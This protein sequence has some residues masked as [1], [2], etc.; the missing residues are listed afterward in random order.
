MRRVG[1]LLRRGKPEAVELAREIVGFLRGRGDEALA[2]VGDSAER[3]SLAAIE[4]LRCIEETEVHGALDLLVVLGGDGTLLR[5][6]ALVSD[7]GVPMLGLNLGALGFLDARAA[8]RGGERAVGA[9]S[10]ASWRSRSACACAVE[11]ELGSGE[12]IVAPRLQRR[13][14]QP[15]RAGAAHRARRA[16]RRPSAHALP[17]RRPHRRHADRLDRLHASP[18]AAP[19]STPEV[20]A[21]VVTPIC[22]HTLT[23][24]PIVV[25]RRRGRII[26][27]LAAP[28]EHVLLTIDGQWGTA[29]PTAI[30][31]DI[32][33]QRP[34]A[35]SVPLA[36][37][38]YFDVL[39]REAALGRAIA[40]QL[41]HD[42]SAI[43]DE[44][45]EC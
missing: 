24:R 18:P 38:S 9:R 39:A 43:S 14:G 45:R 29:W 34:A 37:R 15:G 44:Q 10:T 23:K 32:S 2:I 4:G 42:P 12:R 20:R 5:G 36:A 25:P 1:M 7:A 26:V 11:L 35:L 22:P 6:A 17:R 30:G 27:A 21:V 41:F 13:G 3:E 19:S 16:L 33:S 31:V 28:A 8:R 40:T